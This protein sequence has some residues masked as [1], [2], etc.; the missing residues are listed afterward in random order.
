LPIDGY[1]A[2]FADVYDGENE[3]KNVKIKEINTIELD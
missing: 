1:D 2:G 3:I